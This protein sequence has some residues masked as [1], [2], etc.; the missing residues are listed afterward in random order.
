M[1]RS[2]SSTTAKATAALRAIESE[3]P[4]DERICYDPFAR[5]FISTTF[6]LVVKWSSGYTKRVTPGATGFVVCRCRYFDEYLD[7]SVKSGIDQLVILGAGFDSRGYRDDLRVANVRVFEV[8]HPATQAHKIAVVKRVIGKPPVALRY[9]P[10]D[11]DHET[12]DKLIS[13]GF[14]KSSKTLFVWEGVTCYLSPEAVDSTLSWIRTH[15]ANGSAVIFDYMY[16]SSLTSMDFKGMQRYHQRINE[17]LVFGIERGTI[18]T[19]LLQ[20][21]FLNVVNIDARKLEEMY[22]T[23]KNQGRK[24]VDIYSIAHAEV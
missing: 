16:K 23:G 21:G 11:F 14:E 10:V 24:V 22:C 1:K 2:K 15:A 8:D 17:G 9:V 18:E 12:L 7:Q 13:F 5:K 4:A 6:Y 19:F 3:R 20:R